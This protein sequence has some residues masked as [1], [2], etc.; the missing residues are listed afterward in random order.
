MP[1]SE[2]ND[3]LPAKQKAKSERKAGALRNVFLFLCLA[4]DALKWCNVCRRWVR[5]VVF[6]FQFVGKSIFG[7]FI[8]F[9]F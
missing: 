9:Y 2:Q 1:F 6:V 3:R 5:N 8:A 7:M 4:L